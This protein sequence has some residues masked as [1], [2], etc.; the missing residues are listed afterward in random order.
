M[1]RQ[2]TTKQPD[3]PLPRGIRRHR[4]G[5]IVDVTV[6]GCRKTKIAPTID[7][8]IAAREVLLASTRQTVRDAS[9]WTLADAVERTK[10][11]IWAGRP[12]YES[13]TK[14]ARLI[15]AWFGADTPLSEITLERIDLFVEH[16]IN[17]NGNSGATVNRKLACLS[18]ILR[19]AHERGKLDKLPK[20][21][22]RSEGEHRIRFLS[23]DEER[24]LVIIMQRLALSQD[25]Q[26]AVLCLLYTGF[27]CGELWRLEARDVDL[28]RGTLTAWKTKNHH[29]RTIP[30]VEKLRHIIA[31]RMQDCGGQGR[32]FPTGS[33]EWLRRPWD[34][35]RHHM[36]MDDDAQFVPHML[37]HTCATRL[38][39]AG[40]SLPL[41]KEWLGHTN[42][43]TT[44]R[45]AHFSPE[46]LRAAARLLGKQ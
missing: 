32:L 38:S 26:D 18:R 42:I 24:R 1:P 15:L 28:E 4:R 22:R 36:G 2:K 17:D 16:C 3:T 11:A 41:I 13:S 40:V 35:I 6:N 21:P 7:A 19:T 29:P 25:V 23:H 5:Y 31:R 14:N 12:A 37:R 9:E 46:D 10:T 34:I 27:R 45:Y 39:Q 30:L 43:Q 8:A 44:A 33:N 20:M